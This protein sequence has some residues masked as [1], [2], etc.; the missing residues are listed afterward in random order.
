MAASR[1]LEGVS[2]VGVL[3]VLRAGTVLE[4]EL[5]LILK[6]APAMAIEVQLPPGSVVVPRGLAAMP[7]PGFLLF[8]KAVRSLE[9][10]LL[11]GLQVQVAMSPGRRVVW[12][13]ESGGSIGIP[14][15]EFSEFQK[16][17]PERLSLL[18]NC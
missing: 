14:G 11:L 17:R 3:L 5:P 16:Q 13:P 4:V 12:K 6:A 10:G 15:F 7:A 9:A 1:P 2:A 18:W 8:L